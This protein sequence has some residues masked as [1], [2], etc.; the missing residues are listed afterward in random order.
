[1]VATVLPVPRNPHERSDT[2]G[3]SE[4]HRP[5][6]ASADGCTTGHS[7]SRPD[8]RPYPYRHGR[9]IDSRESYGHPKGGTSTRGRAK[10]GGFRTDAASAASASWTGRPADTDGTS[11]THLHGSATARAGHGAQRRQPSNL[12]ASLATDRTV[13]RH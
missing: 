10:L 13:R 12:L 9:P 2:A 11:A 3:R 5:H 8:H 1:M 4:M 6:C 7:A